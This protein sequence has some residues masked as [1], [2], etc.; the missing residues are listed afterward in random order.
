MRFTTTTLL[1]VCAAQ[2]ALTTVDFAIGTLVWG[3]FGD[4]AREVNVLLPGPVDGHVC[5][6]VGRK[7][8]QHPAGKPLRGNFACK[9]CGGSH[10]PKKW[11]VTELKVAGESLKQNVDH[12]SKCK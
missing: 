1:A 3:S 8:I 11:S 7:L 12:V 9:G 2:P 4:G 10:D 5:N 6:S